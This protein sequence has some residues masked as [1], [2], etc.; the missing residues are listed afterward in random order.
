[1]PCR[2]RRALTSVC[3]DTVEGCG[4]KQSKLTVA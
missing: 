4:V 2:T 1:V 3:I